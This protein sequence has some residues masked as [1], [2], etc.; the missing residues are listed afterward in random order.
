MPRMLKPRTLMPGAK[1][2]SLD[3]QQLQARSGH[4]AE[5]PQVTV[6]GTEDVG[7]LL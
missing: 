6:T 5:Q 3:V 2:S 4:N 7:L 1:G